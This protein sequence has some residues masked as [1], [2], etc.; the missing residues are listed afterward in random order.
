MNKDTY[1][2]KISIELLEKRINKLVIE[3]LKNREII[4]NDNTN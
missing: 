1:H 3:K 2:N 4:N